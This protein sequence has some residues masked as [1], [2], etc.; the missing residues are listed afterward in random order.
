MIGKVFGVFKKPRKAKVSE[1]TAERRAVDAHED[2]V[3]IRAGG[4]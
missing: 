2:Q 1:A 3:E 4:D